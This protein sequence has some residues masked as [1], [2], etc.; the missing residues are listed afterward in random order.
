MKLEAHLFGLPPGA[1]FAKGFVAGLN[2][3]MAGKPPEAMATALVLLPSARMLRGVRAAFGERDAGFLPRLRLI[4]DLGIDPVP[5]LSAAVPPLRRRLELAQL[6][7]RMAERAPDFAAGAGIFSLAGSLADLLAEMQME[8]VSFDVLETLD[9]ADHAAHWQRSLAFLRIVGR[10]FEPDAPPDPEARLRRVVE[11]TVARWAEQPPQHPVIV[12]GSTGSRGATSLLMRAVARLPQGA[13]VLPGFDFEMPQSGWDSLDSGPVPAEDHPQYRF[14]TMIR[15]LDAS[16]TPPAWHGAEPPC[17]ARNA[18]VSLALRPAPVTDSWM[19]DGATLRDLG[20]ATSDITL[21]EA[22]DPRSEATALALLLREAAENGVR[23]ALVSPDRALTRRVAAALDRWGM[24]VDD[25]AGQPLALSP[26]GR[27]LRH[28]AALQGRKLSLEAMFVLLKHPLCATGAGAR[29]DHLRF[30]RDLEL[31][32][33]RHGPAFPD[34]IA[35]AKWADARPEPERRAWAAW[36]TGAFADVEEAPELQLLACIEAHL[37]RAE[38][39]A[40]GPAGT[41]A[42]SEL[43]QQ[44]AGR[45]LVQRVALAKREAVHGGSFNPAQYSDFF[46]QLI[47]PGAARPPE[48]T[49]PSIAILGGFEA[50][51]LDADLVLLAGLNEASWPQAVAPDPWLSRRMRLEAGLL[52]PE[53]QIGLAAHDF[54]Q[55]IAARRVVLSRAAR[56]ADAETVPSR[57]LNRLTNLLG[58]LVDGGGPAALGE[59]RARGQVWL[60]R[61]AL[62][63]APRMVV[64]SAP[65]PAPCPPA[66]ARPRELSVTAISTLIRDPYAIYARHIL[67]L[68]PLDP[69]RP[70]P[71]PRARGE[72]LHMAVEAFVRT[73]PEGESAEAARKRL[74]ETAAEVLAQ[75]VAWP[76]AQRFWLA[77][78]AKIGSSFAASDVARAA[79]GTPMVIEKKG[80]IR[81]DTPDFVLTARPDRIDLLHDGRVRIFDYKTGELPTKAVMEHFDKQLL[82]EAAMAERGAFEPL[83]Q[84]DV[85]GYSYIRLGGDGEARDMNHDAALVDETWAGLQRLLA[86]YLSEDTG[87]VSRRAPQK[88][89]Q[90]GDYDHLAR[91]G[92]WEMTDP[93]KQ[94]R[95]G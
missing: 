75:E 49:H 40:A 70:T 80:S 50:R 54:Q 26:P 8:G 46:A 60:R 23:A 45:D 30:T 73:R 21:I 93:P 33:R 61:A 13:V 62:L 41:A 89:D 37:A 48:P 19:R 68:Y 34:A 29:G 12:A 5:G 43:W 20:T 88:M 9:V 53:R 24:T 92:E 69:L 58:G 95:V 35:L 65:R 79:E 25:S 31:H 74:L 38:V 44:E 64:A 42:A 6:V 14:A 18:L 84:R 87:F 63:D 4:T 32:L 10:Y 16:F 91:F 71:D 86:A 3:R 22:P 82:L 2:E 47:A 15:A 67:R 52:L 94:E 11:A 83:G 66:D 76:S 55:A 17:P 39:L 28:V 1:D 72:V 27:F 51:T 77:R 85:A 36:V 78:I 7:A 59:M 56:T 90:V 57:W 81:L